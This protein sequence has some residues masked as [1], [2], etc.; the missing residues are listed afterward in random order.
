MLGA[1]MRELI[2][3]RETALRAAVLALAVGGYAARAL[4]TAAIYNH[5]FDE[6]TQIAS[7]LELLQYGRFELH[8][9]VPQPS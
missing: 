9:D 1:A 2:A 4:D 7:G 3:G 8:I 5:T 6:P